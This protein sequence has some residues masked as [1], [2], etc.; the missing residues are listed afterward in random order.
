MQFPKLCFRKLLRKYSFFFV[1]V[2]LPVFLSCQ[3]ATTDRAYFKPELFPF[4][5]T[6]LSYIIYPKT[7]DFS[8]YK[9]LVKYNF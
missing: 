1:D 2:F 9:I 8:V 5:R 6:G 4:A 7:E 3:R